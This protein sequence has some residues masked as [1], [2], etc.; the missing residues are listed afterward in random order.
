MKTISCQECEGVF[1]AETR[2][3]MLTILYNHYIEEHPDTIANASAEERKTWMVR[4]EKEWDQ[5]EKE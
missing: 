4:F 1:K 2:E 3:E 5:A